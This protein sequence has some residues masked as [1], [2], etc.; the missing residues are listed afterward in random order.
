M[1]ECNQLPESREVKSRKRDGLT[2]NQRTG[3]VS[4]VSEVAQQSEWFA[5]MVPHVAIRSG[6]NA[7]GNSGSTA[8]SR[9]RQTVRESPKAL[10]AK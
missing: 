2:G 3:N 5:P 6:S 4:W 8:C 7:Y 9:D 10:V 1:K